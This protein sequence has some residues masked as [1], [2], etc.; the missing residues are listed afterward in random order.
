[1][2]VVTPYL[3]FAIELGSL[4]YGLLL[5]TTFVICSRMIVLYSRSRLNRRTN[6]SFVFVYV[7][8]FFFLLPLRVGSV[9]GVSQPVGVPHHAICSITS[10]DRSAGMKRNAW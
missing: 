5:Y 7:I 9:L 2:D 4:H 1:M 3:V 8:L 10:E 6:M